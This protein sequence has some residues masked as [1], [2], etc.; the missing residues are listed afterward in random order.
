MSACCRRS[1]EVSTRIDAW[2]ATSTWIDG[3]SRLS[4][5]SV[6]RHTA[7]VQPMLGTPDEVPHPRNVIRAVTLDWA[8]G[9]PRLRSAARVARAQGMMMRDFGSAEGPEMPVVAST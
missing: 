6:D 5:G 2:P 4:C 7:H 8:R 9:R 1:G 3:R